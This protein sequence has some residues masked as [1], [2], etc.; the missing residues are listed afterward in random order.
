MGRISSRPNIQEYHDYLEYLK[1]WVEYLRNEDAEFSLRKVAKEA[2]MASGY[3][4]MCFNRKRKLAEKSYQKIKPL[5]KITGK[6]EKYLDLLRIVAESEDPKLR[7]NALTSLQKM[8]DYRNANRS[9][10]E[11]HQYLSKWYFVV[12]REMVR[13]PEFS[14][15]EE[16]IQER[17]RGRISQKEISEALKFL[18][19]F[20]FVSKSE[21]GTYSVAEKQLNCEEG[22]YRLS[23]GEFH[24]QMLDWAKASIEEI[25]RDQRLLLGHT[26]TLTREN[27]EKV[28]TIIRES[29]EQIE[30]VD[31]M[32][33][34]QGMEVYHIELAAFPLT[35]NKSP[36][37][38]SV[39]E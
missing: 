37:S 11:V 26:V 6:E 34:A 16:W 22:V 31:N 13:M 14:G 1:D 2:R 20:G 38:G 23:L 18:V 27:F 30:A 19:E 7:V 12:V 21:A 17:L 5:L 24:R 32:P 4:S 33:Q 15:H 28:K 29:I 8:K 36:S 25:P 39:G 35:K 10:L 9:E 3:L